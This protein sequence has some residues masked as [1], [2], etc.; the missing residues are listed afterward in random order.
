MMVGVV[1]RRAWP[2]TWLLPV[3]PWHQVQFLFVH[4]DLQLEA[5]FPGPGSHQFLNGECKRCL[6]QNK[7][8]LLGVYKLHRDIE[9]Y[10]LCPGFDL[11]STKHVIYWWDLMAKISFTRHQESPP[12]FCPCVCFL[13][14]QRAP[15]LHYIL[16][17]SEWVNHFDTMFLSVQLYQR[18]W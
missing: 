10:Q 13:I 6:L 18:L 15:W 9:P 5:R 17:D 7:E 14:L 2:N 12:M 11:I 3:G 1:N 8:N 16:E 4:S